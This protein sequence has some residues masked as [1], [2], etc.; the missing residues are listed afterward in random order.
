M[1][2]KHNFK[3]L[4]CKIYYAK[5]VSFQLHL[6][7]KKKRIKWS[8]LIIQTLSSSLLTDYFASQASSCTAISISLQA[9][10]SQ[11]SVPSAPFHTP[12]PIKTRHFETLENGLLPIE[13]HNF[14]I[15]NT[16]TNAFKT[17]VFPTRMFSFQNIVIIRRLL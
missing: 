3:E 4:F 9:D 11:L 13:I 12:F 17:R 15:D 7:G 1:G 6:P 14:L 5:K 16:L 10:K 8:F 2:K